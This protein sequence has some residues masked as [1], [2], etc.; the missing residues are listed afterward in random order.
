[1]LGA[2]AVLLIQY[3]FSS[4]KGAEKL[5]I[6]T[7]TD[8][9]SATVSPVT[10][11]IQQ[12]QFAETIKQSMPSVVLITANKVVVRVSWR[13]REAREI[14]AGQGSGFFVREDGYIL[15]NYHV[16]RDQDTFYV[17][18]HDGK[19]YRAKV[20]GVDPPTDL[21]LLKVDS[22]RKFRPLKFAD[23]NSVEIGHWAIA[24]GAPFSLEQSVTVGI[25]SGKKRSAV[26]VNVYENYV[27][28]DA[29]VNPG[30]SGGPLLNAKGEVIGVN[31]FILSPSGGSIGLSFAI[32]GDLVESVSKTLIEKGYIE[33]PWLGVLLLP[34]ERELRQR[35]GRENG[36]L[37]GR[38]FRDSPASGIIRAGDIILSANGQSLNTPH[39][40]QQAVFETSPG[41][42][43]KLEIL[44]DGSVMTR[45]VKVEKSP[46]FWMD[47]N[48][49]L[50]G[51][52]TLV[53][54]M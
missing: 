18:T 1:V 4:K 45:E 15:T 7:Q 39:D 24:I 29:S 16:V 26:G 53:G 11:D 34:V 46:R 19:E 52:V 6:Q 38:I 8:K 47:R 23:M 51:E 30:N 21:A 3:V 54:W 41:G 22:D 14:P 20:V 37:A 25:V 50:N 48:F 35:I 10:H 28:T 32:S 9:V 27:Q 33:R 2:S 43:L 44:R 40:L 31:D 13:Q 5:N 36:V 17:T 49:Q 42:K 12:N